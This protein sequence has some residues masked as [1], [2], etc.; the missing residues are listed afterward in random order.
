M[1]PV[2]TGTVVVFALILAALVLFVTE[3]LPPDMTAVAVLVSLVVLEPFTNVPLEAALAGFASPAVLTILAMYVLSEGV[4]KT[5]LV[6][7]FGAYLA[8]VTHGSER[9]LLGAT[10]GTTGVAAGFINNTPVVAVF[11]PMIRDLADDAGVSPS[12][13]LLPLSYA[14]MLGGTLTLVGTATNLLASDFARELP[15]R[16]PIGMF[17]LTPLGVV[18]LGV[19]TLYLLTFG[20]LLTPARVSPRA[21][22]ADFDLD[23]HL[24]RLRIREN[25]PLVGSQADDAVA[26][27]RAAEEFDVHLIHVTS[28][29]EGTTLAATS[30]QMLLP[31][32]TLVV[33]ST[34]QD[35]NRL[36]EAYDLRQLPREEVT[37][38][39]LDRAGELLTAVVPGESSFRN[40]KLGSLRL[41]NVF[42][43]TVL[44]V[45]REGE[46]ITR[47]LDDLVLSSGDTLLLQTTP[48]NAEY[49]ADE[50]DLLVTDVLRTPSREPEGPPPLSDRT[51]YALG[52][53]GAVLAAAALGVLPVV[54]AA[55][56]GVVL[57]VA[58][59]CL[60]TSEAY[61]AV[62]WNVVFL[63][64]GILPL[65]VAMQATGGSELVAAALSDLAALLPPVAALAVVYL[66]TAITASIVTPVASVVLLA[67]IAIDTASRVGA[68]GFA[69]LLAVTF[70]ASGA[71]LTP[72][73]YQTNLMVYGPGGYRF[74][75]Y[76]RVGGP[77]QLLLA[78][79]VPVGIVVLFGV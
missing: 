47:D 12:K 45:R 30:D 64:A 40:R 17:E 44:A 76:L 42:D 34:L 79:V 72:I 14:A 3:W 63:L 49:F 18:V 39:D 52:I 68:D 54:I 69:F 32:D 60:S 26:A 8:E 70:A 73:G 10:V 75:D 11:I 19:G 61:D 9:R 48:R 65:G 24:R 51:P 78:V 16:G 6:E 37:A 28:E 62:S 7:R 25:S 5:G 66:A 57:M 59:G 50:G 15:G 4:R 33:R 20:R 27:F 67:P 2:T 31:G 21:D 43:T 53:L 36:A 58:T 29:E 46:S 38:V 74:T 77:L 22:P 13:L 55:L 35:V 71:F 56:G 1:P 23:D 41:Q